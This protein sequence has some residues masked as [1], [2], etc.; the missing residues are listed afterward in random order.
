MSH[1]VGTVW[2]A[3]RRSA[4]NTIFYTAVSQQPINIQ[5]NHLFNRPGMDPTYTD[6]IFS[7]LCQI[8]LAILI[9]NKV[10]F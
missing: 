1:T 4:K 10:P 3:R 8:I 9:S 6:K 2:L 5:T 7:F